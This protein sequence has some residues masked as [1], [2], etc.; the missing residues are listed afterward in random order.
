MRKRIISVMLVLCLLVGLMPMGV[1][2]AKPAGFIRSVESL[3]TVP[4]GYTAVRTVNDLLAINNA[5]DGKYILMNN[6]GLS[7]T[8]E[9]L[10]S[11]DEPFTGVLDGNGYTVSNMANYCIGQEG[12]SIFLGLFQSIEDAEVRNLT[13]S[14]R[15]TVYVADE[16]HKSRGYVYVGGIAGEAYNSDIYNCVANVIINDNE[17]MLSGIARYYGFGGIVGRAQ[18][19][20]LNYCRSMGDVSAYNYTGGIVGYANGGVDIFACLNEG[21]VTGNLSVGGIAGYAKGT[22]TVASSANE[23]DVL[24]S[25]GGGGIVGDCGDSTTISDCLNTGSSYSS[26]SGGGFSYSG[27]ICRGDADVINTIN[28]GKTSYGAI[29]ACNN[30]M[31]AVTTNCHWLEGMSPR[32]NFDPA[33]GLVKDNTG[34]LTALQMM[35]KDNFKGYEF[36]GLWTLDEGMPYPYPTPLLD[37]EIEN[38]YKKA[39]VEN[40]YRDMT[41]DER[42][43]WLFGGAGEGGLAGVLADTYEDAGLHL[44]NKGWTGIN[45]LN[46]FC[47]FDFKIEND[48]D[49]LL[50]DLMMAY[51]GME[52]FEELAGTEML[53]YLSDMVTGVC[54]SVDGISTLND[55]VETM[56]GAAEVKN[57]FSTA[58]QGVFDKLYGLLNAEVSFDQVG[59]VFALLGSVTDLGMEG[60]QTIQDLIDYYTLANAYAGAGD[61]FTDMMTDI[62]NASSGV[63]SNTGKGIFMRSAVSNFVS[64]MD[65]MVAGDPLA[66]WNKLGEEVVD[67]ASTG[68]NGIVNI[69]SN[70]S[71]IMPVAAGIKMGLGMGVFFGDQI[72]NMDAVAYYGTMM[73]MA[74]YFA[75]CVHKVAIDYSNAFYADPSYEN[76]LRMN[77]IINLYLRIQAL[78][79]QYAF[80]YSMALAEKS[81]FKEHEHIA[82][83]AEVAQYQGRIEELL[84]FGDV[85]TIE[86]DGSISGFVASCPVTVSVKNMNGTEIARLESGKE[87]RRSGYGDYYLVF[88][89]EMDSKAGVYDTETQMIVIEGEGSGTMDLLLYDY[90]DGRIVR[91]YTYNDV[92]VKKGDRIVPGDGV[93][94]V[95][96]KTTVKPDDSYEI[97]HPFTDVAGHW[98]E[99]YI[100]ES[101][102]SG[103]FAGMTPT[104]FEPKGQ[105]TRGQFVTV[106]ARYAGVDLSG[107][108]KQ[109][110]ADVPANAYYAPA[111]QWASEQGIVN[112]TGGG[113]FSPKAQITRQDMATIF[114]RYVKLAG[115]ELA[116]SGEVRTFTDA[117]SIAG[118]ASEAVDALS[119]A[120]VI[121][122]RTDGRFDPR[123]SA[124]RAEAA[125]IFCRFAEAVK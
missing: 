67:L 75:K 13:V 52:A 30:G 120:G 72:T 62:F 54:N 97:D 109:V 46:N 68:A 79:C 80:G 92:P 89:D 86:E 71:D 14:G 77:S 58:G 98:A 31:S 4:E 125:T 7:G 113:N 43:V 53:G 106:L 3:E 78:S 63:K 57:T 38:P 55:M 24:A 122:G 48:F 107:Y 85:I 45:Y 6:I 87:T 123:S 84:Y 82:A 41:D 96:G 33:E 114:L 2:A 27:G 9:G 12:K 101:Y 23:G 76:A 103:Y 8:W 56:E 19:C 60:C 49:V 25:D 15:L 104:T 118:Y 37:R 100:A 51:G 66:M 61:V 99:P 59:K 10:C 16:Y 65:A 36:P 108:N 90:A 39:Y 73:D 81:L 28:V 121:T 95:N 18:M 93:L 74:G 50:A 83:A 21:D 47:S 34:M 70:F 115:L 64:E 102:K 29:H 40:M 26:G 20:S 44:V 91:S 111:V 105:V 124:T 1:L 69:C 11:D 116:D 112:G 94:M 22:V 42:F 119:S 35:D 17:N 32:A 110:F 88:G 5:P 117:D